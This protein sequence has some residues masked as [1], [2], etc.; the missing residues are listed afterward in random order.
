MRS[1]GWTGTVIFDRCGYAPRSTPADA[2]GWFAEQEFAGADRLLSPGRWVGWGPDQPSFADQVAAEEEFVGDRDATIVLAIDSRWLTKSRGQDAMIEAL[3]LLARPTALV[4]GDRADPLSHPGAVSGLI[5][6]TRSVD[7][8]SILRT[9]HGA[10]GALAFD[11]AHGSIG[12]TPS[13]RHFIPPSATGSAIPNDRSA[14]V[15]VAD[16]M[17]WFTANTIASWS[18]VT[19]SPTCRYPCCEGARIDRFFDERRKSDADLHNR[20]VL[21]ALADDILL[22]PAEDRRRRFAILCRNAIERYGPMGGW[23]TEITPK[24]QLRQWAQFA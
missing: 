9:D 13:H 24:A 21:A 20:T 6:L 12:L 1:D 5:A 8:L 15:F 4:L 18:P 22:A 7:H 11:A 19:G 16:L 14:R 17:D 3:C 2:C 10:I 23:M